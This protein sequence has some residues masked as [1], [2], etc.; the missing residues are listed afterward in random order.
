MALR[1]DFFVQSY[2]TLNTNIQKILDNLTLSQQFDLQLLRM[3]KRKLDRVVLL[4]PADQKE[5]DNLKSRVPNGV[6]AILVKNLDSKLGK[7]STMASLAV[8]LSKP[9]SAVFLRKLTNKLS[10]VKE[11]GLTESG[12]VMFKK[13]ISARITGKY[14]TESKVIYTLDTDQNVLGQTMENDVHKMRIISKR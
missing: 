5:F 8:S 7:F 11:S 12:A 9:D 13:K 14:E 2:G 10:G 4:C 3:Q 1:K 6:K